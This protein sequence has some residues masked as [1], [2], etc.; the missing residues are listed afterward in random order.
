MQH[1]TAANCI[2]QLS[3]SWSVE[4]GAVAHVYIGNVAGWYVCHFS[5][6]VHGDGG[7]V[8]QQLHIL[9][10][11]AWIEVHPGFLRKLQHVYEVYRT[12]LDVI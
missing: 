4:Q 5:F 9:L 3:I 2:V 1:R 11:C 12:A 8:Q 7:E 6:S 10:F